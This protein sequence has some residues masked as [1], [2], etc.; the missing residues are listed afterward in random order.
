MPGY[1]P[2]NFEKVTACVAMIFMKLFSEISNIKRLHGLSKL[3][4]DAIYR[5]VQC[6]TSQSTQLILKQD[7][8]E[9]FQLLF[10]DTPIYAYAIMSFHFSLP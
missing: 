6:K 2:Q 3:Y 4:Q 8:R 5:I 10:Y 7:M 9:H 1:E